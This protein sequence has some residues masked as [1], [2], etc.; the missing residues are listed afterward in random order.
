MTERL[1]DEIFVRTFNV[2]DNEVWLI[3][4]T[5]N[6][7]FD[8][9]LQEGPR[10]KM[11][12]RSSRLQAIA[13]QSNFRSTISLSR[14]FQGVRCCSDDDPISCDPDNFNGCSVI[15][16]STVADDVQV[17]VAEHGFSGWTQS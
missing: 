10:A 16:V 1:R 3:E 11:N 9:P 15:D 13:A 14:W 8:G 5:F 6:H 4:G 12:P 2:S 17:L 7:Q